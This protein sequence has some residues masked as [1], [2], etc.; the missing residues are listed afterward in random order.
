MRL[1]VIARL[2]VVAGAL[3][4]GA[5]ACN[6]DEYRLAV[7]LTL[8]SINRTS[9]QALPHLEAGEPAGS[10]HAERIH[11]VRDPH[12]A[13]AAYSGCDALLVTGR[14]P[15]LAC[16]MRFG[17]G[18]YDRLPQCSETL[19]RGCGDW[20]GKPVYRHAW[21]S[22]YLWGD[23]D[24]NWFLGPGVGDYNA[25]YG[26]LDHKQG[27]ASADRA[28]DIGGT[29]PGTGGG[30]GTGVSNGTHSRVWQAYDV[31]HWVPSRVS[32][33]CVDRAAK[34]TATA[35]A[36]NLT[37]G[38]TQVSAALAAAA[39][40]SGAGCERVHV[41]G[42]AS[43]Y[44]RGLLFAMGDYRRLPQTHSGRPA[45]VH[46]RRPAA[47]FFDGARGSWSIS[48]RVGSK[49]VAGFVDSNAS[50]PTGIATDPA[51]AVHRRWMGVVQGLGTWTPAGI[52]ITCLPP[53]AQ[54]EPQ[55]EQH[56]QPVI[57]A[58]G[59]GGVVIQ[60][61]GKLMPS[62]EAHN[63]PANTMATVAQAALAE[64]AVT[65]LPSSK[66]ELLSS[67]ATPGPGAAASEIDV[68]AEESP[69]QGGNGVSSAHAATRVE[70]VL[71]ATASAPP[72]PSNAE[73]LQAHAAVAL[74]LT[75]ALTPTGAS[76]ESAARAA[77][78]MGLEIEA[79]H[80]LQPPPA[81]EPLPGVSPAGSNDGDNRNWR[82]HPPALASTEFPHSSSLLDS[83]IG[84]MATPGKGATALEMENVR[85]GACA[86]DIVRFCAA[87]TTG[88]GLDGVA[89]CLRDKDSV[90]GESGGENGLS[91]PCRR[92]LSQ[93]RHTI[94]LRQQA[95]ARV[96]AGASDS[97]NPSES[98]SAGSSGPNVAVAVTVAISAVV[99]ALAALLVW[100]RRKAAGASTTKNDMHLTTVSVS[101]HADA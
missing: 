29:A 48:D 12:D 43:V 3:Y 82:L 64:A 34:V 41:G 6:C 68:Q 27:A 8:R 30:P 49:S 18:V 33:E 78:A 35:P 11:H 54:P 72:A 14:A 24:D 100:R 5:L 20:G 74:A 71:R 51:G 65:N 25:I 56:S 53:R 62:S 99:P 32:I 98:D 75:E 16:G 83:A 45:Y 90:D 17:F 80:V 42:W 70:F 38:D 66:V 50:S 86:A 67:Q 44:S 96:S 92:L 61:V 21:K 9:L 10:A 63:D 52:E 26:Y 36:L 91:L 77:S 46:T 97:S 85:A 89:G 79:A 22:N 13:R 7:S 95:E 84:A 47:L 40:A 94:S 81:R 87:S 2:A 93:L 59:A 60:V 57:G 58:S 28:E 1:E 23:F 19:H 76:A 101:R 4:G 88:A 37:T 55:P 15:S 31:D 39:A 73:T 69:G